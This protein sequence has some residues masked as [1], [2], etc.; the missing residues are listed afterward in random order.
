VENRSTFIRLHR[1]ITKPYF[2]FRR[3]TFKRMR[4]SGRLLPEG[5]K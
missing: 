3:T 2:K 1:I 5:S 4:A